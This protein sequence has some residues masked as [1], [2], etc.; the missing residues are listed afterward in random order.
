MSELTKAER[1][2]LR[3]ARRKQKRQALR[4]AESGVDTEEN[5]KRAE[6]R[7]LKRRLGRKKQN[8]QSDNIL[9]KVAE[10]KIRDAN[11]VSGKLAFK[12]SV[13]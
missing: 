7:R 8:I 13:E 12:S 10:S 3:R 5:L 6:R 2:R 1:R 11:L 9:A 4:D